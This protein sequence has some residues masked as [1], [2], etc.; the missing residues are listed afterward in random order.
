MVLGTRRYKLIVFKTTSLRPWYVP[1][2]FWTSLIL[3]GSVYVFEPLVKLLAN[4]GIRRNFALY[5]SSI[6][7]PGEVS[8]IRIWFYQG[9]TM[10][11]RLSWLTNSAL[12]Y[13]PKCGGRGGGGGWLRCLSQWVQPC[14]WIPNKLVTPYLTCGFYFADSCRVTFFWNFIL[15]I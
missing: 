8:C 5:K 1:F 13:E 3:M 6:P 11:C 12:V 7:D 9:V 10:R 2:S 15:L 4:V 14:T